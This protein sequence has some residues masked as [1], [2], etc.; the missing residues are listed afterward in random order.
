M[1]VSLLSILTHV[2]PNTSTE[3]C[4]NKSAVET[5]AVLHGFELDSGVPSQLSTAKCLPA[6]RVPAVDR[7]QR[8]MLAAQ[9]LHHLGN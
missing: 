8:H 5:S 4:F 3:D 1:H 6:K 9:C 2:D 7:S